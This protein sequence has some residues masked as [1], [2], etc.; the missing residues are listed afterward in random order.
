MPSGD[1]PLA[2]DH[3]VGALFLEV[4]DLG[5]EMRPRDDREVGIG[6]AAVADDGA[7]FERFGNCDNQ[8]FGV[9]K[10]GRR[11]GIVLDPVAVDSGNPPLGELRDDL[12]VVLDD[13]DRDAGVDQRIADDAPTR[14]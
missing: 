10:I 11:H 13:H 5:V 4:I 8:P 9:G 6:L 7:R 3:V 12:L 1:L 2:H 14:P